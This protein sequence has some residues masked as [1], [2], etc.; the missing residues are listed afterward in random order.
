MSSIEDVFNEFEE[1]E[2][3]KNSSEDV[4]KPAQKPDSEA[5]SAPDGGDE[6]K[7]EVE[8]DAPATS[9]DEDVDDW[10]ETAEEEPAGDKPTEDQPVE[11]KSV[12]E[13]EEGTPSEEP[14]VAIATPA[15]VDDDWFETVEEKPAIDK[16]GEDKQVEEEPAGKTPAEETPATETPAEAIDDWFEPSEDQ[17]IAETPSEVSVDAGV[18]MSIEASPIVV[19]AVSAVVMRASMQ[20]FQRLKASLLDKS[21][22]ATIQNKPFIK[23]SGW[24]KMALAFNLSDE[25]VKDERVVHNDDF[26]CRIWVKVWAPNGRSVVGIGACSSKERNFAHVEHDV[27]ATAHTRAKNRALS[28]MIGS[29]EVSWEELRGMA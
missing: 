9:K 6:S 7:D 3:D 28:D 15:V 2:K 27:Y 22:V 12:N 17:A 4:K 26:E 5:V 11:E 21:D 29:G 18:P 8:K 10:F 16:P 14:P 20:E 24:R 19:P 23:R 1:K 13:K 25:I